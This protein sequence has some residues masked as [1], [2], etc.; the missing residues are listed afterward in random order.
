MDTDA[1]AYDGNGYMLLWWAVQN[2]QKPVIALLINS[3]AN[4]EARDS[5]DNK[6]LQWVAAMGQEADVRDA[7]IEAYGGNGRKS[8]WW[9]AP[10]GHRLAVHLLTMQKV[11]ITANIEAKGGNGAPDLHDTASNRHEEVM[12]VLLEQNCNIE[13]RRPGR[14]A[15]RTMDEK[16]DI[17]M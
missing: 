15:T 10:N 17:P 9:A 13:V 1:N 3:G 7:N 12:R 8:L 4:I 5:H 6:P 11:N 16:N 2:G 14:S